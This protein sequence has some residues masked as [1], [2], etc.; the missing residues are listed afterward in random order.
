MRL[1]NWIYT[2]PL[3]LRSLFD[4]RRVE[5]ELDEELRYHIEAKTERYMAKGMAPEAARRA[6]LVDFGGVE[7][8]KEE[9]RDQ[10]MGNW[11][12]S[13][14][15]D[16]RYGLRQL[17]KN[18]GFTAVAV[19]TLALGIGA[20]SALFSIVNAVLLRPLPY[21]NSEQLVTLRESKP[22]F[23]TGS[24]SFP[25]FLDWRKSNSTFASMAAMR[26]GYAVTLTGLGDADQLNTI[27]LSSGFFEQLGVNPVLGRTFTQ[28]EERV[29]AAPTVLLA[30]H[31]W[32]RKFAS[33]PDVL[34][35]PLTLNGKSYA[36]IGVIPASF[37]LLGNFNTVDVYLPIGQ[38]DN[39]L[40]MNRNAGLGISAIGRLKPGITIEQARADMQHISQNLATAYPDTNKNI[41]AALIPFRRWNLGNVQNPLFVLLGAVAF[42]LLIACL[43]VA[44]LLLARSTARAQ[45]FAVRAALGAAQSRIVR[46]LLVE[47]VLIAA[48]G[49]GI[50]LLLAAFGTHWVLG[51]L[52]FT[53][54]RSVEIGMDAPVFLFALVV[55]LLAGIFFG[56]APALRTARHDP[57]EAL[58]EGG[59]SGGGRR[60]RL[61][62]ALVAAEISLALVL[63][64]GAG[65]M[66]RTFA[67]LH[68]VNPGFD[69]ARV[70]AFGLSLPP[71]MMNT[72]PAAV[73]A[74]LR[75][76]QKQFESA[77]GVQSVA[78]SWG[79]LPLSGD[80]EW[81]FW[82]DGHSKPADDSEESWAIDYVVGPAYLKAMGIG[83]QSGRFFTDADDEHATRVAVVDEVFAKKFFPG[84]NPIGQR[85]HINDAEQ[86]TEIVGVV[87]H[88]NQWGLDSDS[89]Q[90]LRSE[91]YVPLM[92]LD[93]KNMSLAGNGIGVI[94]RSDKPANVFDSIRRINKQI[95]NQQVV[96]GA[97]TMDEIIAI[98]LAERRFSLILLGLFAAL[99]LLLSG[100]GIY[101]VVSY[102]VSQHS[103]EIGIRVALGARHAD[104][105]RLVLLR[106]ARMTAV[107]ILIGLAASFV[108]TRL[109]STLLYGVSAHDTITLLA[110]ALLLAAVSLGACYFPARRASRVDPMVA[111]HYE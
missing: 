26:G 88:V 101:G 80:D 12:H 91:L 72:D 4:G 104:V 19:L 81:L 86:T 95:S 63:L 14:L 48:I 60:H 56:L 29:G 45:E 93:D 76:V 43:N 2:L 96:F 75:D 17:R 50:G 61:Q 92:Q 103:R 55:S 13:V 42:V 41:S 52:P 49:G 51:A 3:R 46:Q 78:Y 109:L 6:A 59:R 34:G 24:I 11:L 1:A 16:C 10:A 57:Q 21:P 40:L 27:L 38:W 107:G 18:P 65:L 58:Q 28:D 71:S 97:Q 84:L 98:S 7:Q 25:N 82:I 31:F 105:L 68:N 111:L 108:L 54:P 100:V 69:S 32:K 44:N 5:S 8:A 77:P 106:G 62:S 83:L 36:I 110:V 89:T 67:A 70:L 53:L 23:A 74:S 22:N 20:N 47:S 39:P 87:N 102:I 99:A 9:V 79:A 90:E 33:A 64:V 85:L 30:A 35:K 94:V 37:D 66:I 73:R 15:S